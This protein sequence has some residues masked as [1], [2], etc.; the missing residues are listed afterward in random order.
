MK[1]GDS[2]V[3]WLIDQ[4]DPIPPT[5]TGKTSKETLVGYNARL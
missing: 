5:T 3:Y 1:L 4:K 2:S